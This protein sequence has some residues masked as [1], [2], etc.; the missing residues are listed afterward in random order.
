MNRNLKSPQHRS[1]KGWAVSG[2]SGLCHHHPCSPYLS[3][4]YG[5]CLLKRSSKSFS[6]R[7]G[8]GPPARKKTPKHP[9]THLLLFLFQVLHLSS[10]SLQVPVNALHALS[11]QSQPGRAPLEPQPRAGLPGKG[12]VSPNR[13]FC[14]FVCIVGF[15][16]IFY[17]VKLAEVT[18]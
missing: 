2:C 15:I 1:R 12:C 11:L 6:V 4:R 7:K 9:P 13:K 10:E 14:C 18:P 17:F 8:L 3:A 16:S 5:S